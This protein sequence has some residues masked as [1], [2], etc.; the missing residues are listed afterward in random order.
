ML[1]EHWNIF[2]RWTT[3]NY[4][5]VEVAT[6]YLL[7]HAN[8]WLHDHLWIRK[9]GL[10]EPNLLSEMWRNTGQGYLQVWDMVKVAKQT[11][12][13]ALFCFQVPKKQND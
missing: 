4:E 6:K 11:L 8:N 3:K 12:F 13:C 2:G 1:K 7:T 5:S 9:N 10:M